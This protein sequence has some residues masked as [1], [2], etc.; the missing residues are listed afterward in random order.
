MKAAG[1]EVKNNMK[2]EKHSLKTI[3]NQEYGWYKNDSTLNQKPPEKKTRFRIS[4]E[5]GDTVKAPSDTPAGK[6]PVKKK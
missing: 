2:K 5:D 1:T 3:L 6:N 4:W